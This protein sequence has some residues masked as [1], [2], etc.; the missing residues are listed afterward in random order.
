[1][2]AHLAGDRFWS[3]IIQSG[4]ALREKWQS[5][6][7]RRLADRQKHQA[8]PPT[9]VQLGEL[10]VRRAQQPAWPSHLLRIARNGP[11]RIDRPLPCPEVDID[12]RDLR[13]GNLRSGAIANST[14]PASLGVR[15]LEQRG[16]LQVTTPLTT[17]RPE[18][19]Q[20]KFT[21]TFVNEVYGDR[22]VVIL[23]LKRLLK[24]LLR[25]WRFRCTRLEKRVT[26]RPL[27]RVLAQIKR[28]WRHLPR[29][30]VSTSHD[31]HPSPA[32][33]SHTLERITK[34]AHR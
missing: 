14:C 7:T 27:Q 6:E 4:A 13:S 9:V 17:R 33:L 1:M 32:E 15:Q 19:Q 23:R 30:E 10:P 11:A 5:I 20:I 29:K 16:D 26:S 2:L 24:S 22:E 8:P 34:H 18:R 28:F 31:L 25:S 3:G 21:A 12:S